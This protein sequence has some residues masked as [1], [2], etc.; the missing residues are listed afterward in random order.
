MISKFFSDKATY[1]KLA[2][3]FL[4]LKII[5]YSFVIIPVGQEL[6][7]RYQLLHPMLLEND[8]LKSL[9]FSHYQPPI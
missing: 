4:L 7:L 8:L 6:N 5:T 3:I 1:L 2:S 9:Y